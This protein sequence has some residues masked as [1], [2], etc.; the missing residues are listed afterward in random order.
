MDFAGHLLCLT[1]CSQD[2]LICHTVSISRKGLVLSPL[3]AFDV[4][5]DNS[6]WVDLH[7][8]DVGRAS[9]AICCFLAAQTETRATILA[10]CAG[11]IPTVAIVK[12]PPIQQQI[13]ERRAE[14]VGSKANE[15]C[16]L[17]FF[18]PSLPERC[19]I[20]KFWKKNAKR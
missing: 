17:V 11:S 4:S 3:Y 13:Q 16:R 15:A 14:K 5:T 9:W 10:S 6:I 8:C 20:A 12:R 1:F 7:L 2:L 18:M 19:C